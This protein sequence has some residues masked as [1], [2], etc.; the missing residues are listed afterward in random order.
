MLR[1]RSCPACLVKRSWQ[2]CWRQRSYW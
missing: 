2:L 1:C